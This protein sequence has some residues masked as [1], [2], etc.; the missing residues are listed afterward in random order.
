MIKFKIVTPDGVIYEDDSVEQVSLPTA[1]GYI[2][3]LPGHIPIVSLLVAGELIIK[4]GDHSVPMAV[5]RGVIEVRP[6]SEVYILAD[7][8][9]R[10]EH[11]DIARAEAA[12]ARAEEAMRTQEKVADVDFAR[13]QAVIERELARISVG[14]KYRK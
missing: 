1:S 6:N 14:K 8:A 10:A 13:L 2:T 4:K 3:V 9:E 7:T 11:I 5:S 12:K